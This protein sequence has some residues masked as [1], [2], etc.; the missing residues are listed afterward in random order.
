MLLSSK[1]DGCVSFIEDEEEE[2]KEQIERGQS[3][4]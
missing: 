2:E 3:S 1:D 4:N